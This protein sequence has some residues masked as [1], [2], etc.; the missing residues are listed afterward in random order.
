MENS[1][2][3]L[4]IKL[5]HNFIFFEMYF[6]KPIKSHGDVKNDRHAARTCV[7]QVYTR[8]S[9]CRGRRTKAT[10]ISHVA[11]ADFSSTGS[12]SQTPS[13]AIA[14]DA[15]LHRS[16]LHAYKENG[17]TRGGNVQKGRLRLI[18]NY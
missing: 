1:K 16:I 15:R 8:R 10:R 13:M 11:S 14:I 18:E 7:N 5:H 6:Y 17:E 4:S 3:L 2:M 9:L 12:S